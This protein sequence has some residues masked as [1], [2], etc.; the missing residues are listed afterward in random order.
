MDWVDWL[1]NPVGFSTGETVSDFSKE[2]IDQII[3]GNKLKDPAML[4]FRD[5]ACFHAGEIH[6]CYDQWREIAGDSPPIQH[7]QVLKWIKDKVSNIFNLF[8][9]FSKENNIVLPAYPQN[10]LRTICL[11]SLWRIL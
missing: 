8:L 4:W 11:V 5:S 7:V 3:L 10:T 1:G 6:N 9:A 2:E